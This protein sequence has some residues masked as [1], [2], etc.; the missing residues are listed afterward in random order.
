M[1]SIFMRAAGVP[2]A[3]ALLGMTGAGAPGAAVT[4]LP[5]ARGAAVAAPNAAPRPGTELW[6][7][8]SSGR[9][10]PGEAAAAVAVSPGG[11]KVFV[12]GESDFGYLTAGYRA[13]TG[14]RLWARR[15]LGPSNWVDYATA[16]AVSP[17]GATVFV[18]GSSPGATPGDYTTIAYDAA[19]GARL[20]I[21]RYSGPGNS[22]DVAYSIAV[23]AGG[24]TVFV[25][26][27]SGGI[28]T[29]TDCVT[30]AYD[31]ATGAQRWA[32]TYNGPGGLDDAGI[33]LAASPT[34]K[35]VFVT[36]ASWA[37]G[38]DYDYAT[39]AYDAATGAQ[40]WV[41]RYN[42]LASGNDTAVSVA[43]SPAGGRVF[44][45]GHSQGTASGE[46]YATVAYSAAT[47]GRIW[48]KRYNGPGN[49]IDQ[50]HAVAVSPAGG[51]VFVTGHSQGAASAQ[52]YA[53]I[54]YDAATGARVWVKRYNGP[55]NGAD[56][57]YSVAVSPAGGTVFVTGTS[58][59]SRT[60]YDC[61]TVAYRA[62]TGAQAWARRYN[63]PGNGDDAGAWVA[64]SPAGGRVFVT[65]HS[66]GA[67]TGPDYTTI[68]YSG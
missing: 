13:A 6:V 65:G 2:A 55:G 43:V 12:T 3:A 47:G 11:D 1:F 58:W 24:K 14:A 8:R 51:R 32:R 53:T 15:Y 7:S 17:S 36:G 44:V 67:T 63:G 49:G 40:R 56:G 48:V 16:V 57:G 54:A 66:G 52:D 9:E 61:T 68:G 37:R 46:D 59:A 42:G 39:I 64:V 28:T 21:S 20:W 23:G 33:S 35:T 62:A 18:T 27:G 19:T 25:T 31:A 30:V 4:S 60:G 38:T 34:G 41:S 10:D 45:T 5:G 26:G 22:Y 29:D 50:A